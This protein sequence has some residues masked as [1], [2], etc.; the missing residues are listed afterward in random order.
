MT[1]LATGHPLEHALRRGMLAVW[2]GQELGLGGEGLNNV[3]YVA[4]LGSV[5]CTLEIAGFA[6]IVQDEIALG[7]RIA[8]LDPTR[9]LDVAGFFIRH[10][11]AGDPPLRRLR[12]L[13]TVAQ[14][15]A[16]SFQIVCRDVAMQVG[17]MIDIGPAVRQA[18]EQC[19]ERWDGKGGP[20][21]LK[22]EEVDIAARIF[23]VVHDAE[24]F[25][26]IG[27]I[28][29]VRTVMRQRSGKQ[30]DPHIAARF[31]ELA[32]LLM[33]SLESGATWDS[34]L[35]AEPAPIRWISQDEL[36]E[37]ARAVA[38]FVDARS[39][40]TLG[41]STGVAALAE[42]AARGLG[43]SE[44][45][46]VAVRRAGL[47]H[48]MGRAGVPVAVW[49]RADPLTEVERER[50][51]RHPSLTELVLARSSALG[52]LGT[53]AGLHHERLDGSGYRGVSA[54]F[55]PVAARVLA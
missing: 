30:H 32:P 25:N 52:N 8:T 24:V 46:A 42:A 1:D 7:E 47:L 35:S 3:Y 28:E 13:M 26:R 36:D 37:L 17:D 29:A 38:N 44:S 48:D 4:L 40:Y 9:P 54:S 6:P 23:H 43:L 34:A 55:L 5:G 50:V 45:E 20:R 2:L 21:R 11:G 19:H 16:T 27:G 41:H 39:P 18:L 53:L 22:G 33:S 12:K 10:A 51:R 31:H 15:G 49:D 14:A